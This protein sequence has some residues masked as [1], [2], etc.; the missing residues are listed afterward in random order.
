MDFE[1]L[2]E[3]TCIALCEMIEAYEVS[4][5][6]LE[7][8]NR[9]DVHAA[10]SSSQVRFPPTIVLQRAALPTFDGKYEQWFKFKQMF[11]DIADKCTADSAATKLHYL[12]KA[13]VG[14]AQGAIDAQITRDNDYE[15]AWRSLT[16]QFENL[17]ALINDTINKLLHLKPMTCESYQQLKALIDD[18]DK[19]VSKFEFPGLNV[20][21]LSEAI[22]ATLI[23]TKL[24]AD[25]RKVWESNVKR[26][27]LPVYKQMMTALR[28]H[29]NILE[30]CENA[31][32]TRSRTANPPT[33]AQQTASKV[34]TVTTT[35]KADDTCPL[36][37]S[38]HSADK[39]DKFRILDVKRRYDK[40]KQFGLCF[41]CL[42]RGHRTSN[43]KVTAT[44]SKCSK[45]H[46]SLMHPEENFTK[47]KMLHR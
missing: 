44:C 6:T 46:H 9:L 4:K 40:A 13:L 20:D 28:D 8:V 2:Y 37:S 11:R 32:T 29:L 25:S 27:Q 5:K 21:K 35:Q 43:C 34:H 33:R 42:K 31:R 47:E 14:K 19:C 15:G 39:C 3:F 1:E 12:D 24:D 18:V 30:R 22:L 10:P 45:R 41:M 36:C 23:S 26:G 16:Q 38:K 17:P 7:L